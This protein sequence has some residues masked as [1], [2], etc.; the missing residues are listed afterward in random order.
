MVTG[1]KTCRGLGVSSLRS[2]GG[3]RSRPGQLAFPRD[4]LMRFIHALDVVFE[5]ATSFGELF[6]DLIGAARYIP[7][8]PKNDNLTDM[9]FVGG[10]PLLLARAVT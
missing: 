9:E 2:L 1:S 6:N 10:H 3:G 7:T 4:A 5:F 8:R